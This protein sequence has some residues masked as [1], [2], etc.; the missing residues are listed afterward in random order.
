M[1]IMALSGSNSKISSASCL[2]RSS[3][4][5]VVASRKA[6][7]ISSGAPGAAP[8][9]AARPA[10]P[11]AA[12]SLAASIFSNSCEMGDDD[13][14]DEHLQPSE[15]ELAAL[16]D[17]AA[18]RGVERLV[19]AGG[20]QAEATV[21]VAAVPLLLLTAVQLA[22]LFTR[23]WLMAR[24]AAAK[25]TGRRAE[26]LAEIA[27]LKKEG[28][29]YDNVD[30]WTKKAKLDRKANKLRRE[31]KTLPDDKQAKQSSAAQASQLLLLLQVLLV[32]MLSVL[33]F[34]STAALTVPASWLWPVAWLLRQP[35][36]Q[37]GAVSLP[38]WALLVHFAA[39]S[40]L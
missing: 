33:F 10:R 32:G 27:A 22:A 4:K 26:L 24:A 30:E 8:A 28:A 39:S 1:R 9:A 3:L 5:A 36:L 7:T 18:S 25:P 13:W 40:L 2:A 19:A 38:V 20:E 17:A 15:E 12:A 16:R 34:P 21:G 14:F 29:R 6:C 11:A 37:A 35:G 23:R 31:L